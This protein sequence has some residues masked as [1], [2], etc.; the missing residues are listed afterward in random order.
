LF[1]SDSNP[2]LFGHG[3]GALA[4]TEPGTETETIYDTFSLIQDTFLGYLWP[5]NL[6]LNN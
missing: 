4:I 5:V 1:D 6:A 3:G 2:F